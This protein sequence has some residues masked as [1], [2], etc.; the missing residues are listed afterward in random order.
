VITLLFDISTSFDNDIVSTSM[1]VRKGGVLKRFRFVKPYF[2]TSNHIA[3]NS[4]YFLE[5]CL[6]MTKC[7]AFSMLNA[8][9]NK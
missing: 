8:L 1:I 7:K 9:H 5:I 4:S 2:Q 6:K 3:V